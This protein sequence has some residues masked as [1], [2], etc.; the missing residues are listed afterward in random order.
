MKPGILMR[1]RTYVGRA[2]LRLLNGLRRHPRLK[3]RLFQIL[4]LLPP[5]AGP[6]FAFARKHP[7]FS[8]KGPFVSASFVE[9]EPETL[10][11]WTRILDAE[12][13]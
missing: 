4:S 8:Q 2:L 10:A 9:P 12:S 11:E 3:R 1:L 7:E 13:K 6:F 5:F